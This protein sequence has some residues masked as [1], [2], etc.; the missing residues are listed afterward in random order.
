MR[1]ILCRQHVAGQTGGRGRARRV[2]GRTQRQTEQT[3]ARAEQGLMDMH[4]FI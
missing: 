2:S 4:V 1:C 3:A